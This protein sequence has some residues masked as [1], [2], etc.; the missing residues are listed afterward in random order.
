MGE[1]EAPRDSPHPGAH[2]TYG[3]W[4]WAAGWTPLRAELLA[5]RGGEANGKT[6]SLPACTEAT[7]RLRAPLSSK[8]DE[9]ARRP[10][11]G[12]DGHVYD[13]TA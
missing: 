10:G 1:T 6:P 5:H 8:G 2:T 11:T 3:Q 7:E 9:R 4:C 12:T 13:S